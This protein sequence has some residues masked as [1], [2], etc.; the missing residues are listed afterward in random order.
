MQKPDDCV[1]FCTTVTCGVL[2]YM[3]LMAELG[4]GPPPTTSS[5][6]PKTSF[7]PALPMLGAS[8]PVL[9]LPPP[10]VSRAFTWIISDISVTN[11]L[12]S[13]QFLVG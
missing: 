5:D 8:K 2:K 12:L 9:G 10:N 6:G 13:L 3:S 4:Q 11:H 1:T 7:S